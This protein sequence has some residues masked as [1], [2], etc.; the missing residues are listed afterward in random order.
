MAEE[1]CEDGCTWEFTNY[2]MATDVDVDGD[3]VHV[4]VTVECENCG[5]EVQ[6]HYS[7]EIKA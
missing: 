6:T 4:C 1:G 5:R 7:W 3:R 2:P